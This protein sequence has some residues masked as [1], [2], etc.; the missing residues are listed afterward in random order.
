MVGC[1]FGIV[2]ILFSAPN[3]DSSAGWMFGWNG[4]PPNATACIFFWLNNRRRDRWRGV[5][6]VEARPMS[7]A[8]LDH[9][10]D[11]DGAEASA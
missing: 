7:E 9:A 11:S 5:Q 3:A 6:N 8:D 2:T 4:Q 1:P 10:A